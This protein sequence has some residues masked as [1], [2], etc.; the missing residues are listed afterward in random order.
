MVPSSFWSV[1]EQLPEEQAEISEH[2]V[3]LRRLRPGALLADLL[4]DQ[5]CHL[6][7]TGILHPGLFVQH[8]LELLVGCT[9]LGI[10]VESVAHLAILHAP[11]INGA[12]PLA[13]A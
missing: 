1:S 6:C 10:D 7:P 11:F 9:R 13:Q 12:I 5:R 2:K 3:V 8:L 4:A